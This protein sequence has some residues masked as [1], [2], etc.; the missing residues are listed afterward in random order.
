MRKVNLGCGKD[1]LPSWINIDR[2]D[3]GQEI[4]RDI[5][6]GLPFDDN[7][8]D[9]IYACHSM[10]H[11]RTGEDL[12]FVMEEIWRVLKPGAEIFIRV[13]HS[14]TQE[15]SYPDHK[16]YWNEKM[17]QAMVSDWSQKG[18]YTFEITSMQRSGIELQVRLRKK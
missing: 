12:F 14:S 7:S 9:E 16:S 10:E 1:I 6:K 4:V 5:T 11:I 3:F 13:P 2:R 17:V 8:V 18:T 15:A